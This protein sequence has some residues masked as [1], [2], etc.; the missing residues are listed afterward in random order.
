M[1]LE[2]Y[3]NGLP[4]ALEAR[5]NP[6]ALSF[7]VNN[8]AELK[9]RQAYSTNNFKIP[10]TAENRIACGFPGDSNIIGIQP[11]RKN[12]AKIVQNGIEIVPNGIAVITGSDEFISV[13]V[14][15][16]IIGF[17]DT[18]DGKDISDL[19]LSQY[20]HQ[21]E[22]FV[23][24]N[25]Q[26]RTSGYI[27]PVIDYGAVPEEGNVINVKQMRPATFLHTIID[28]IITE[29]GYTYSGD[30]F[31]DP[32]YLKEIIP[33]TNDKFTHGKSFEQSGSNNDVLAKGATNFSTSYQAPKDS[34]EVQD[35]LSF[36]N[37]S[38]GDPGGHWDGQNYTATEVI[39]VQVTVKM[40]FSAAI[41]RLGGEPALIFHLQ[42]SSESGWDN[43]SSALVSWPGDSEYRNY[44]DFT[45]EAT[46]DLN[47]GQ[48]LR[49][50]LAA[51]LESLS[52]ASINIPPG[53]IISVKEIRQDVVYGQMIQLEATLP[54]ISQKNI[55]KDFMQRKGLT[56]IPDRTRKHVDFVNLS[57]LYR[58]KYKAKDWTS[59]FTADKPSISYVFQGYGV[60]NVGKFKDDEGVGDD[61]GSGVLTLDNRTLNQTVEVFTSVFAAS[62][63]VSKLNGITVTEIKKIDKPEDPEKKFSVKT[64]P[65]ILVNRNIQSAIGITDGN[66]TITAPERSVPYFSMS[67]EEGLGY[68][69]VFEKYYQEVKRM[70]FRPFI[71]KRKA[72]LS[73]QD[74]SELDFTI[75]I[76]D[77][78]TNDYYYLNEIN[79]YI[80]GR[81]CEVSLIKLP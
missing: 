7:A 24:H 1:A 64:E 34:N 36:A 80:E 16:G 30:I 2:L 28:K 13:Q 70:L 48:S 77:G 31:S 18:I 61:L 69:E 38:A 60:E 56:C 12:I 71:V 20:E 41:Y 8:L 5:D 45:L 50:G 58:N 29:A 22:L 19:D 67:G 37:D 10:N 78:M 76:F 4:I 59:K 74:I 23:V 25:S 32:Q 75:P 66:T 47:A 33:F 62:E 42:R 72:T 52:I 35:V 3:I 17:F 15:S 9:D 27:Y 65:R 11:Y 6:I 43:I 21:W 79:D 81:A 68:D 51:S 49:V 46:V 53:S 26:S 54:S 14:L 44:T 39:K 73:E 40:S 57:V 55:M 63:S